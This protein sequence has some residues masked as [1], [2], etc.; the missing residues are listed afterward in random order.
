MLYILPSQVQWSLKHFPYVV[1]LL[2]CAMI[3]S[4]I[5]LQLDD[6]SA[7]HKAYANYFSEGLSEIELPLY[8]KFV[9]KY[10]AVQPY[11]Q[12]N[13]SLQTSHID[14]DTV[15]WTMRLD[16]VFQDALKNGLIIDEYHPKYRDWRALRRAYEFELAQDSINQYGFKP[17]SPNLRDSGMSLLLHSHW[18]Y[19]L[20]AVCFLFIIGLSVETKIGS[21]KMILS[22]GAAQA[23]VMS[24]YAFIHPSTLVPLVGSDGLVATVMGMYLALYGLKK[25]PLELRFFSK[26]AAMGIP[27]LLTL[28]IWLA[29]SMAMHTFLPQS[30]N[31]WIPIMGGLLSGTLLGLLVKERAQSSLRQKVVENTYGTFQDRYNA[32]MDKLSDLNFPQAKK[33][34][35]SLHKEFPQ[36]QEILFQLFNATKHDP[37]SED[38]HIV[39]AKIFGLKDNSRGCVSMMNIVFQNY[40]KRAQ[41]SIR[42]EPNLYLSVMQKFRRYGYLGDAEKILK[43]LIQYNKSGKLDEMLAR[44][45]LLLGRAF[46]NKQDSLKAKKTLEWCQTLYPE[47]ASAKEARMLTIQNKQG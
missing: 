6:H 14:R 47:T 44:E 29:W 19:L 35:Y 2:L 15:Y 45:Q 17:A 21:L 4:F 18:L 8:G 9:Q 39:V 41:P 24:L 1:G 37:S 36:N 23:T 38:Y 20:G 42:F 40:I 11:Y 33:A 13:Q 27:G 28:F 26:T 30:F 34:F 16:P 10:M 5:L 22:L 25:L 46:M 32:A 31:V 12:L 3:G 43:V 7:R